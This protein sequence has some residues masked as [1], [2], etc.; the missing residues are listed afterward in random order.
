MD[1]AVFFDLDK[2]ILSVATE[3]YFAFHLLNKKI[4]RHSHL[5]QILLQTLKYDLFITRD[6]FSVKKKVIHIVL[7]NQDEK[8]MKSVY[9]E[10]FNSR[11]KNLIFPEMIQDVKKHKDQNRK[12]VIISASLDF[13]VEAFCQYLEIDKYFATSLEIRNGKFTGNTLGQIYMGQ[14][15]RE[16]LLQFAENNHINLQKSYAYGDYI[17]DYHMLKAVGNPIA[18]NPDKKLLRKARE[19]NWAIKSCSIQR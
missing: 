18:V 1:E 17:E 10:F 2:T 19:H 9:L 4:I 13:I 14:A 7:E 16:A 15:K 12:M 6:F 5:F 8:R 3:N 11:L